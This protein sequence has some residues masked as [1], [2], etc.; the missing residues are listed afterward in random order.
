MVVVDGKGQEGEITK[1]RGET[2]EVKSMF[3]TLIVAMVSYGSLLYRYF[4]NEL[5]QSCLVKLPLIN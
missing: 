5:D 1:G 4:L 3:L 2:F